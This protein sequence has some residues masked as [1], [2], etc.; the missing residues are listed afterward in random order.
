MSAPC[1][2][3]R[4]GGHT[5]LS[6]PTVSVFPPQVLDAAS[7]EANPPQVQN[8]AASQLW[9]QEGP[10]AGQLSLSLTLRWVFP[11]GRVD[12]FRVLSQGARCRQGQSTPQLLGLT[13]ACLYRAVGLVVPR[14][15]DG[16]SCRLEL[17][18]EPV[19]RDELPVD[20]D[21]WGRL[22]LVYSQPAS[23]TS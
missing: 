4:V 11:P 21:R 19:L 10:E 13:P 23:G 16:E 8:L 6:A 22:V 1:H 12:C 14:P 15:A 2:A 20:P 7:V 17:L 18:V 5:P 3:R 9:W